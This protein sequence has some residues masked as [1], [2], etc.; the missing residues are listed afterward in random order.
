VL[1]TATPKEEKLQKDSMEIAEKDKRMISLPDL[2]DPKPSARKQ[3]PVNSKQ[4]LSTEF[5]KA[6]DIVKLRLT[7]SSNVVEKN[8]IERWSTSH[9][10]GVYHITLNGTYRLPRNLLQE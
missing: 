8:L 2:N 4:G 1:S 10:H 3:K 5:K 9:T 7:N 6:A